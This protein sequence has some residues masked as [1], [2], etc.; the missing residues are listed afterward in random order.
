MDK[1]DKELIKL[2]STHKMYKR[3]IEAAVI[4][5]KNKKPI[6]T[7]DK[8]LELLK[9]RDD[10]DIKQQALFLE[11][12]YENKLRAGR[13]ERIFLNAARTMLPEPVFERILEVASKGS[14]AAKYG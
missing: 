1:L 10:I 5:M 3:Q 12:K 9:K 7:T 11:R 2:Q 13:L 6:M 14:E 4:G 8:Y